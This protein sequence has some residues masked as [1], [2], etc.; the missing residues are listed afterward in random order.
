MDFFK[1]RR[2]PRL[3]RF[4]A[5]LL[6]FIVAGSFGLSEFTDIKIKKKDEKIHQEI[7]KEVNI[8]KWENI[9]GPRPWEPENYGKQK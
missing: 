8:D 9:R 4:G 5:P 2:V 3:I 1:F 7:Q 6:I